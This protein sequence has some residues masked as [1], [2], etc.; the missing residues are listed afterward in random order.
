MRYPAPRPLFS[1]TAIG[2][3][4]VTASLASVAQA[5]QKL[6][7]VVVT[8]Q[9]RSQSANDVGITIN[10]FTGDQLQDLGVVTAEDIAMLTPGLTV[11]ET[12]ATG[13]PLYTIRGVGF[14]DYSTAASSTVG[15]YFDEVAMP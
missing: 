12:A 3:A 1:K 9:K 2:I 5:Q 15:I 11:N 4:V 14:Q 10:A 6:E 7:E 13:V 8:A